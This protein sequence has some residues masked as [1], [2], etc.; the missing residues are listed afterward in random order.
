MNLSSLP[1]SVI[2]MYKAFLLFLEQQPIYINNIAIPLSVSGGV[3][4][5]PEDQKTYNHL[6]KAALAA[7]K[8][9]INN[10]GGKISSLSAASHKVLNRRAI[11]DQKMFICPEP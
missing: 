11:I 6:M 2:G 7:T 4:R 10:G 3:V 1:P 8:D 9:V 5:Y